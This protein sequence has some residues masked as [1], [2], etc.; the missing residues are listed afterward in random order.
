MN[1]RGALS[2]GA[3]IGLIMAAACGGY[4]DV[5]VDAEPVT[6]AADGT[7][8]TPFPFDG[9]QSAYVGVSG[10]YPYVLFYEDDFSCADLTADGG[11]GVAGVTYD[12]ILILVGGW[13]EAEY[14][15]F[16]VLGATGPYS[17]EGQAISYMAR[18]T[19]TSINALEYARGGSLTVTQISEVFQTVRGQFNIEFE[20]GTLS[21][22]FVIREVCDVY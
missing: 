22:D 14:P 10:A 20:S 7:T 3:G 5:N 12:N 2:V 15:I 11:A 21:G 19:G 1:L 17:L 4:V 18:R 8:P 6:P 16:D 9:V 13:E